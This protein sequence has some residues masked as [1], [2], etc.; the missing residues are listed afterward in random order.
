LAKKQTRDGYHGVRVIATGAVFEFII[1]QRTQA[2]VDFMFHNRTSGGLTYQGMGPYPRG[3]LILP[4]S[5]FATALMC[6]SD[7][8]EKPSV[9]LPAA[10]CVDVSPMTWARDSEHLEGTVLTVIGL[11][12]PEL[13]GPVLYGDPEDWPVL[14]GLAPTVSSVSPASAMKTGGSIV[15]IEGEH[16]L[17]A[18]VTFDGVVA[19]KLMNTPWLIIVKVPAAPLTGA[20]PLVVTTPQGN[21]GGLLDFTYHGIDSVIEGVP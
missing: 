7:D 1:R 12:F 17:G 14:T 5:E 9:C 15:V 16:L 6:R 8:P 21:T 18:T 11:D 19:V 13:G 4:G 20:V 2:L 3:K 10:V